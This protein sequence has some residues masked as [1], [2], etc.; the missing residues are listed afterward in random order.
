MLLNVVIT[1]FSLSREDNFKNLTYSFFL[2]STCT[3]NCLYIKNI[4]LNICNFARD[5][6]TRASVLQNERN[7]SLWF[8]ASQEGIRA[9]DRS[10]W[11]TTK[12]RILPLTFWW[13]NRERG[14]IAS[15]HPRFIY[16]SCDPY[17]ERRK[18]DIIY[19]EEYTV[20]L[21]LPQSLCAVLGLYAYML[22]LLYG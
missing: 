10:M 6:K 11:Q 21:L 15:K 9:K 1:I 16:G 14:R 19:N 13:S 12:K 22:N 4:I 8:T 17:P 7:S 2:T 3:Q 18:V 5:T 20:S